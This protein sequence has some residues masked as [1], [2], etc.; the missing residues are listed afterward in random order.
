M[1]T[2]LLSIGQFDTNTEDTE[3]TEDTKDTEDTE[4]LNDW[5]IQY[6][7]LPDNGSARFAQQVQNHKGQT[8]GDGS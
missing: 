7:V 2:H 1:K 8:A 5:A 6:L 3:D 4:D